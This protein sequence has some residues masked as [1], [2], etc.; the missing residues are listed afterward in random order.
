MPVLEMTLSIG[1]VKQGATVSTLFQH[2]FQ[3]GDEPPGRATD[4]LPFAPRRAGVDNSSSETPNRDRR[5]GQPR[6][7]SEKNTKVNLLLLTF[8]CLSVSVFH[9][10]FLSLSLSPSLLFYHVS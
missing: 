1:S 9:A 3:K 8:L 2:P 6:P 7:E 5:T 4:T 10:L